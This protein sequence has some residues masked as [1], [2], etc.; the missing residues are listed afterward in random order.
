MYPRCVAY[1]RDDA[2]EQ[3][4]NEL[5]R[6]LADAR[7]RAGVSPRGDWRAAVPAI[8]ASL[9]LLTATP[10][11]V[12]WAWLGE[13]VGVAL[14][15]REGARIVREGAVAAIRRTEPG[16]AWLNTPPTATPAPAVVLIDSATL[17]LQ[18]ED[19]DGDPLTL[20]IVAPPRHGTIDLDDTPVPAPR[21]LRYTPRP[22]FS[23]T[24]EIGF[25]VSDGVAESAPLSLRLRVYAPAVAGP[26]P[27]PP[28]TRAA[29][30]EEVVSLEHVEP[31]TA[32]RIT[33]DY[34]MRGTDILDATERMRLAEEERA[35]THGTS[36]IQLPPLITDTELG[37]GQ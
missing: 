7:A 5:A 28:M 4:R 11:L 20:R 27:P 1:D 10:D 13:P 24:D 12:S 35:R 6:R 29:E 14:L 34:L 30:P 19:A 3:R 22:G 37:G 21:L 15:A 9:A 2:R 32:E 36:T 16:R 31:L 18:G 23:G 25:A 26:R 8:G 17:T 33:A